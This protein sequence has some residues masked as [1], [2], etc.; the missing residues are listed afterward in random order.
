[1]LVFD[2]SNID[3]LVS[4]FYRLGRYATL[5]KKL[6]LKLNLFNG[7]GAREEEEETGN[8]ISGG[9]ISVLTSFLLSLPLISG[10]VAI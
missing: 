4:A 3:V 1:V 9:D 10:A 6:L 8:K 5:Y 7:T 2:V